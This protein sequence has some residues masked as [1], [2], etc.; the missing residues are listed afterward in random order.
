MDIE[1]N[2]VAKLALGVTYSLVTDGALRLHRMG[3]EQ[4]KAFGALAAEFMM[5]AQSNSGMR[6]EFYTDSAFVEMKCE[7]APASSR[8]FYSFDLDVDGMPVCS[9]SGVIEGESQSDIVRFILPSRRVRV[10]IWLPCL[11]VAAIRSFSLSDG[12]KCEAVAPK[13]R[14]AF[15]GDS[16]TQGYD[17]ATAR[18]HYVNRL[19]ARLGFEAYNYAIGAACFHPSQVY[20]T[21]DVDAVVIAYGTNDWKRKSREQFIADADAFMDRIASCYKG[22]PVL[23]LTPVWRND[24]DTAAAGVGTFAKCAELVS[25]SAAAHGFTVL[26][27]FGALPHDESFFTDGLHPREEGFAYYASAVEP[28]LKRLMSKGE[29]NA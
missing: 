17:S 29:Q 15:Y 18:G 16:I 27:C 11:A 14:V 26:D 25:E 7:L 10:T 6:L 4:E 21:A 19:A 1:L 5:K 8:R 28:E 20:R 22:V 23:A 3:P 12:A 24:C 13:K 2:K 9:H